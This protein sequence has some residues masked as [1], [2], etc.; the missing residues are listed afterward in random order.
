MNISI[1]SEAASIKDRYCIQAHTFKMKFEK[2]AAS[3]YLY[4]MLTKQEAVSCRYL[5]KPIIL[6][7]LLFTSQGLAAQK[8]GSTA[9]VLVYLDGKS[10]FN[11]TNNITLSFS[12]MGSKLRTGNVLYFNPTITIRS[13]STAILNWQSVTNP[14][15]TVRF[16]LNS[17]LNTITDL[18]DRSVYVFNPNSIG[19]N[20][21][22]IPVRKSIIPKVEIESGRYL[23][24]PIRNYYSLWDNL[25]K[26]TLF[27]FITD[28]QIMKENKDPLDFYDAQSVV[29]NVTFGNIFEWRLPTFE[30]LQ[31]IYPS[32]R[33]IS[34]KLKYK[35][36]WSS[37]EYNNRFM[38]SLK[39][40]VLSNGDIYEGIPGRY[41]GYL[42]DG[43]SRYGHVLAV[44]NTQP[45]T[46]ND[47]GIYE[48]H[49]LFYDERD[50]NKYKWIRAG[51]YIWMAQNLAYLPF[52]NSVNENS[53][54]EP[55]YYVYNYDGNSLEEA[56]TREEYKKFGVL[57][58]WPAA[59][60]GEQNIGKKIIRGQCPP[61]WHLPTYNEF[62]SLR[63]Y[64]ENKTTSDTTLWHWF[65]SI[66]PEIGGFG[67]ILSGIKST[68]KDPRDNV[69]G[70]IDPSKNYGPIITKFEHE[71][72]KTYYWS[73][74]PEDAYEKEER[75]L[76]S[77]HLYLDSDYKKIG[78]HGNGRRNSG[79][80]CRCVK[81]N[82]DLSTL[83]LKPNIF[84]SDNPLYKSIQIIDYA[85]SIILKL[86]KHNSLSYYQLEKTSGDTSGYGRI[87]FDGNPEFANP[88]DRWIRI[89]EDKT[90]V[91]S[92][93]HLINLREQT[94]IFKKEENE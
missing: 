83:K 87:R 26:K 69:F 43:C 8:F 13:S 16:L 12:D 21:P 40:I 68:P 34:E 88:A 10:F 38:P 94:I 62:E 55:R 18:N 91:K 73:A 7:I 32:R 79:Y 85:D 93:L 25:A 51:R 74:N 35:M 84:K 19:G 49:G 30:E 90:S 61:G 39:C 44:S 31:M 82:N 29:E 36:Y 20:F 27:Y 65:V 81:D 46:T 1:F 80:P 58:N 42:P 86:T 3:A 53:S 28:E 77:F 11:E 67:S 33:I 2:I 72:V 64:Y 52:V 45:F 75:K 37:T 78:L 92:T 76:S 22:D 5:M 89:V 47:K 57:Y 50:G 14:S 41:N 60:N 66:P 54:R 17:S 9:D 4:R 15:K 56:I 59:I 71:G 48:S 24:K 23:I 6:T 63:K 70:D